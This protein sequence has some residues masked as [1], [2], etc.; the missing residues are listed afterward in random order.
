[1]EGVEILA[2]SEGATGFEPNSLAFITVFAFCI[3]WGIAIGFKEKEYGL[4]ALIGGIIG[5]C[6]GLVVALVVGV[7]EIEYYSTYK[8]TISD[9]VSLNEFTQ[10]YEI[11]DQDGKIYT[12]KE[13]TTDVD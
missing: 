8:V 5:I 10:K 6:A 9:N 13:K 7:V 12:V 11:L 3:I 4:G 2:T 1:M